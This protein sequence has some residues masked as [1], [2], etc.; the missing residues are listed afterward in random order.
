MRRRPTALLARPPPPFRPPPR[1]SRPVSLV[2]LKQAQILGRQ[3]LAE[4][5]L[6]VELAEMVWIAADRLIAVHHNVVAAAGRPLPIVPALAMRLAAPAVA[7]VGVV[8]AADALITCRAVMDAA[9]AAFGPAALSPHRQLVVVAMLDAPV[10]KRILRA[11]RLTLAKPPLTAASL[12][13][14][15]GQAVALA[16]RVRIASQVRAVLQLTFDTVV[17]LATRPE[18]PADPKAAQFV[19]NTIRAAWHGALRPLP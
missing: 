16:R 18:A 5:A 6:A 1:P 19:M 17:D 15:A 10:H 13:V 3:Q 9:V 8:A 11:K 2:S 12:A 4:V 7:A 14:P